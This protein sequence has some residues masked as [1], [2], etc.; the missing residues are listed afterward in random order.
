MFIKRARL[1]VLPSAIVLALLLSTRAAASEGAMPTDSVTVSIF[2]D[3]V[4]DYVALHRQSVEWLSLKGIDPDSSDGATF[5]QALVDAIRLAR[6][7]AQPGDLFNAAIAPRILRLLQTDL[8][9]REPTERRAI[10]AEVPRVLALRVNDPYPAGE[11]IATMPPGLLLLL[12]PLPPEI[13]YRFLGR[14]L[15]LLDV[16]ANLVVDVLPYALPRYR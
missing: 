9:A 1:I 8:A 5:R 12:P 2:Q 15:I 14:T 10:F 6:R 11:P 3:R 13:Q 16:D 4:A 7:H